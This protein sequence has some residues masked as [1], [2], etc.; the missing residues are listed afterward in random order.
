MIHFRCIMEAVQPCGRTAEGH[1]PVLGTHHRGIRFRHDPRDGA[2][3]CVCLMLRCLLVVTVALGLA[4]TPVY[5]VAQPSTYAVGIAAHHGGADPIAADLPD[6]DPASPAKPQAIGLTCCH[7]GCVMA[8][9]PT[10]ASLATNP[11]PWVVIPIPRDP[12][13]IPI[14]PS[15][16]DRPPKY[17]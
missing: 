1:L 5:A 6:H 11:L 13:A 8:L 9:V 4:S 16:I 12:Q 3:A 14:A 17:A 15:G 7:P 10:V 2:V